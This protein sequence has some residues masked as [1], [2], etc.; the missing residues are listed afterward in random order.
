MRRQQMRH[1]FCQAVRRMRIEP[2]A[3]RVDGWVP[4]LIL[5]RVI[6]VQHLSVTPRTG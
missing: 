6:E 1:E 2:D 5:F 3:M 4:C